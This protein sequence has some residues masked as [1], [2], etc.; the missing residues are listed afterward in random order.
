MCRKKRRLFRRAKKLTNPIHKAA[1]KHIQNENYNALRWAHWSNVNGILTEGLEQCDMNHSMGSKLSLNIKT[2]KEYLHFESEVLRCSLQGLYTEWTVQVGIHQ[3][4]HAILSPQ[5]SWSSTPTCRAADHQWGRSTKAL[6]WPEPT[7]SLRTGQ[8]T[9]VHP[10]SPSKWGS[11]SPDLP[12][13]AVYRD[14]GNSI[15]VEKG[16]DYPIFKK[17]GRADAANYHPVSLTSIVCKLPEHI[18]CSHV[19]RHLDNHKILSEN[20]HG[21]RAKHSTETQLLMTT[22]EML[23]LRDPGKQLN[24]VIGIW[25][26]SPS[27]THN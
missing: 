20:N 27:L 11:P 12:L 3:R 22:H 13:P 7:E 10:R 25:Q 2:I 24:V 15:P 23:K 16:M 5:A 19:R 9:S 26:G 21:F 18:F 8:S 1:Y 6:G 17:G 4:G 14:W